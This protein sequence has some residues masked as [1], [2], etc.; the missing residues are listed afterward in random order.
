MVKRKSFNDEVSRATRYRDAAV[1]SKLD[2]ESGS[3]F[4]SSSYYTSADENIS[5]DNNISAKSSF[6]DSSHYFSSDNNT[7]ESIFVEEAFNQGFTFSLD[8]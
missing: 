7:E 2:S 4:L 3:S 8:L 1:C 6:S 5:N